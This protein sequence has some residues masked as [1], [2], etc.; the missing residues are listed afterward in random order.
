MHHV[1]LMFML[2]LVYYVLQIHLLAVYTFSTLILAVFSW[3]FKLYITRSEGLD[4]SKIHRWVH[5]WAIITLMT[6]CLV[7]GNWEDMTMMK[8]DVNYVDAK[9]ARMAVFIF[10]LFSQILTSSGMIQRFFQ[11]IL[12]LVKNVPWVSEIRGNWSPKEL[13]INSGVLIKLILKEFLGNAKH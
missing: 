3:K 11:P 9:I 12:M 8:N 10:C 4:R 6:F 7:S 5:S 1:Y 13:M 2:H